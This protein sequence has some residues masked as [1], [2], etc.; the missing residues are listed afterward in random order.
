LSIAKEDVLLFR[1][2]RQFLHTIQEAL[3]DADAARV[4]LEGVVKRKGSMSAGVR[5][6]VRPVRGDSQIN[7]PRHQAGGTLY[8]YLLAWAA[9]W[10]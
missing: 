6:P 4:V 1:E 9:C 7:A 8:F 5:H 10:A 2:Q 3:A